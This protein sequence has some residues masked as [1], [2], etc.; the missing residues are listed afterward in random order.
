MGF[1]VVSIVEIIYFLSVRP[2]CA[3]R[4]QKRTKVEAIQSSVPLIVGN[5][6]TRK[7]QKAHVDLYP[8]L[9]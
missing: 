2:Y 7:P 9:N 4:R 8:Y 1:S 5:P 3:A 6:T